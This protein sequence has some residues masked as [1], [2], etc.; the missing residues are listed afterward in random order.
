MRTLSWLLLGTAGIGVL[1]PGMFELWG[2]GLLIIYLAAGSFRETRSVVVLSILFIG[3]SFAAVLINLNEIPFDLMLRHAATT[4]ALLGCTFGFAHYL[5]NVSNIE[6]S[7]S[8][9]VL[10]LI[11]LLGI[12][13][14]EQIASQFAGK[15]DFSTGRIS[16]FQKDAN[17]FGAGSIWVVALGLALGL[18]G[19]SLLASLGWYA[20]AAFGFYADYVSG[21]R[22]SM[23]GAAVATMVVV[24]CAMRGGRG[25]K[26]T[27]LVLAVFVV[28]LTTV[29]VFR[30]G[31][32]NLLE[33][34]P[35]STRAGLQPY[36][37]ERFVY[38]Y[39]AAVSILEQPFGSGP[40]ASMYIW[41]H[42]VHNSFLQV[43]FERG[44]IA[45]FS[46]AMFVLI[47]GLSLTRYLFSAKAVTESVTAGRW[48][49]AAAA[50][51]VLASVAV[52]ALVVD[53]LHWRSL[54]L[55]LACGLA[56][57]S[58]LRV[59]RLRFVGATRA[60]PGCKSA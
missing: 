35:W 13:W 1:E 38:Q 29:V 40:N 7:G 48:A 24:L 55:A 31:A 28:A 4:A 11:L 56:A 36:D 41:S 47:C 32:G 10:A 50:L 34:T 33:E 8:A 57:R 58:W 20:M 37:A 51:G 17:I 2:V 59:E 30:G 53:V 22:G 45:F 19:R 26:I 49:L 54:W 14:N 6:V 42:S 5:K 23:I 44:W 60:A 3:A 12:L 9:I 52:Q 25:M 18:S 15:I 27:T 46:L 39:K 43:I 21:S 16:G